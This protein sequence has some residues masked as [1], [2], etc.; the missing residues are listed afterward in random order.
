MSIS[1]MKRAAATVLVTLM[2]VVGGSQSALA[3]GPNNTATAINTK[4]NSLK[5]DLSFDIVR[6]VDGVVD[7]TNAA[8]AYASCTNCMSVAIAIQVVLVTTDVTSVA[9]VNVAV[10]VN[11]NCTSCQALASAFQFIMSTGGPV[12][13]SHDGRKTLEDIRKQLDALRTSGLPADQMLAQVQ[14][15]DAQI[16][17]VVQTSL[18]PVGSKGGE[19]SPSPESSATAEVSPSPTGSG[20]SASPSSSASPTATST[21]SSG[22]PSASPS[23][24]PS[25]SSPSPSTSP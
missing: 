1:R 5:F 15:L 19:G 24:T 18:V 4:D 23:P 21:P 6:V 7:Q 22:T 8:V 11:Q 3:G 9:P 14:Q 16:V 17:Q 25:G 10:A 12:T 13:L 2:V 20:S